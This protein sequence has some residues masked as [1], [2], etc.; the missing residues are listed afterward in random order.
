LSGGIGTWIVCGGPYYLISMAFAAANMFIL[1]RLIAGIAFT[2]AGG[3]VGFI[4]ISSVKGPRAVIVFYLYLIS[5]TIYFSGFACLASLSYPGSA[6]LSGRK[7]I[8]A[9]I[10][11]LFISPI[12]TT[13][14]GH[15]S[16]VYLVIIYVFIGTMLL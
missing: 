5:L 8:L 2:I 3:L 13:F 10:P 12:V 15:D 11:I 7:V 9:S 14:T 1:I 4:A 6:F 16:A